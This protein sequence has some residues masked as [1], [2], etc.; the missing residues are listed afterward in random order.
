MLKLAKLPDPKTTKITF[1]ASASLSQNLHGYAALYRSTYGDSV[2]ASE[3]I[4]FMLDAFLKS[5]P[6]FAKAQKDGTLL[7]DVEKQPA[8][9]SR[10]TKSAPAAS[11]IQTTTQTKEG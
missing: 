9:A 11:S 6:A 5:D 1:T 2:S 3:L 4:P 10:A 8:R 7:S